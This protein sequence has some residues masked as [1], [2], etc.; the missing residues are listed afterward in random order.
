M[1]KLYTFIFILTN[2]L[3]IM[4]SK[5]NLISTLATAVW[6]FLGG[7]LIWGLIL[8]PFNADHMGTASGV[9]KDQD[10]IL[11]VYV[12]LGSLITG[13]VLSILY[14][15]WARGTHSIMQGASFGGCIGV[16]V[17]FGD[18]LVEYGVANLLDLTGTI[19]NGF[20]YVVFFAVMGIFA[21]L[22]YGK[23]APKS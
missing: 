8:D 15:K 9:M 22:C 20:A 16:I 18:R 2:K 23:F 7:Y 11:F 3:I 4:F 12:A 13:F 19:A 10:N 1:I 14:S 17:G 6:G 5:T 21:S